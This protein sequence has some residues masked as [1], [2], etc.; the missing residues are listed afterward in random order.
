M[1]K[2][3]TSPNSS[4]V[5]L[6]DLLEVDAAAV[7]LKLTPREVLAKSKGRNPKI[8]AYWISTKTVRFH[9]RAVQAKMALDNGMSLQL[10]AAMFG[11]IKTP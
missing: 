6:D 9:P 7:W 10:I 5:H 11:E 8:A 2:V 3:K 1:A 4:P